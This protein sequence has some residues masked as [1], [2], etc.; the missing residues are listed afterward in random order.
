MNTTNPYLMWLRDERVTIALL[1]TNTSE[2]VSTNVRLK[3]ELQ[4]EYRYVDPGMLCRVLEKKVWERT[5]KL[6]ILKQLQTHFRA[7]V[8]DYSSR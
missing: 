6:A 8:L 3:C 5:E 2:R 4:E 1:Y 7:P